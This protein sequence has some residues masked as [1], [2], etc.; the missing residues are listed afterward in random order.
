MNEQAPTT[1]N[2]AQGVVEAAKKPRVYFTSP[3]LTSFVMLLAEF[4]LWFTGGFALGL[5]SRGRGPELPTLLLILNALG[6]LVF[7]I[8]ILPIFHIYIQ[9]GSRQAMKTIVYFVGWSALAWLL[10]TV[11]LGGAGSFNILRYIFF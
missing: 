9:K 10:A 4:G 6:A 5:L 1:T 8:F 3:L 11:F 7:I 2:L